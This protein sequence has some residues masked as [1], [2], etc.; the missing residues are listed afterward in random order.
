MAFISEPDERELKAT[1]ANSAF[2]NGVNHAQE[3]AES[4]AVMERQRKR[5]NGVQ[6]EGIII[7]T[8]ANQKSLIG[9]SK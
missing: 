3:I 7:D 1:I 2:I 5:G 9:R 6:L 4:L 8:A